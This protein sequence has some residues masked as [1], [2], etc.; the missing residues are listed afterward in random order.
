MISDDQNEQDWLSQQPIPIDRHDLQPIPGNTFGGWLGDM[1]QAVADQIEAPIELPSFLGL[2]AMATAIQGKFC[3]H[4]EGRYYEPLN[5]WL[6]AAMNPSNRKSAAL[7]AMVGPIVQF[8]RD[9]ALAVCPEIQ[10]IE[11]IRKTMQ[12]SIEKRRK[13]SS[14]LKDPAR[15]ESEAKAIAELEAGLP[16]VPAIPRLLIND[17]TPEQIAVLMQRHNECLAFID[18]EADSLFGII[19]GRYSGQQR[20]DVYLKGYS[21]DGLLVDRRNGTPIR[22]NHPKLTLGIAPQPGLIEEM[23]KNPEMFGRGFWS[24]FVFAFPRSHMGHRTLVSNP[25]PNGI[26]VR[27]E[28]ALMYLLRLEQPE[29]PRPIKLEQFAMELLKDWQLEIE[30]MFRKDGR[31]YDPLLMNFGGKIPGNTARIAALMHVAELDVGQL[32]DSVEISH[33]VMMRA[34]AMMRILIDHGIAAHDMATSDTAAGKAVQVLDWIK[35]NRHKVVTIRMVQQAL[36]QR[37]DFRTANNVREAFQ[38]LDENGWLFRIAP[39]STAGGPSEKFAVH[40][41]V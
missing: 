36:K 35:T 29:I 31:F 2:A 15:A 11:S 27:Y 17:C 32:P 34:I 40:P 37:S 18:S 3:V 16:T 19:K 38:L 4:V 33:D 39:I 41:A 1:A 10:R 7:K 22:L 12:C 9:Q 24:R 13:E 26:Q 30:T 23:A 6:I 21:G 28:N 20:M 14:K 25:V 8:E 5:I